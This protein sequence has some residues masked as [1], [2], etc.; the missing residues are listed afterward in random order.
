MIICEIK[1][2]DDLI[3]FGGERRMDASTGLADR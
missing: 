1:I 2:E 3:V